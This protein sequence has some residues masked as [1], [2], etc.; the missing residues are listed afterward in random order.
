[1]SPIRQC[2]FI[3]L[4]APLSLFAQ[5]D[6][7]TRRKLYLE[8]T[9]LI[10]EPR[11]H[12]HG[13]SRRLNQK[14]STWMDWLN[15][16]G[17]LPPDFSKMKSSIF[18]PEPLTDHS[19]NQIKTPAQWEARRNWIKEQFQYW[20][21]GH[22][23]PAPDNITPKVISRKVED[24]AITELIEISFGPEN[25]AKM[26][27]ELMIPEGKGPFP[28]YMTQW[29]H[30]HWAQLA[31]RRG[32]IGCV[33]AGAD[34]KDDTQDYQ[35]IYP[36]YDFTAL[37]RRAWG[38]SRVVDY[39]N[40]R[41]EV[42]K[43]QIAITGH[44]RNGKQSLWAGAF[45]SRFTAV[46]SS[47]CGTG[48]VT[49][50]RFTDPQYYTQTLDDIA[51]NAAH[52]F[53]PRLR[54]FFGR[55][56]K[57]PIDQNLLLALIAPRNLLLHSSIIEQQLNPWATE[58]SYRSAKKVF[59]FFGMPDNIALFHRYGEH[60]VTTRDLEKCIDFLDQRFGR[61]SAKWHQE[62]YYNFSWQ[63]WA[64]RT[65]AVKEQFEPTPVTLSS[66]ADTSV[67]K[68]TEIIDNLQWLLGKAPA[69]VKPVDTSP[70]HPSRMDWISLTTGRPMVEGT[71]QIHYGPYT[72]IGDHLSATL[73]KPTGEK[74]NTLANKSGKIPIV[75][76]L[77]EYTYAHGYAY[78]YNAQPGRG[79]TALFKFLADK[80][81]AILA[82]DMLGFGTRIEEGKYFYD[83]FP[84]WSKMG[85]MT[86]DLR[87]C[88]DAIP[89]L[90][91]IDEER[92]MV[93]G[94]TIGGQVALLSAAMDNRIKAVATVAAFTPW[95]TTDT[96]K[97]TIRSVS[98]EHGLIPRLGLY[99]E[100]P[101]A[102]PV[103]FP[104]ILSTIAPRSLMVIAPTLDKYTDAEA[105]DKS[106]KVVKN[107]FIQYRQEDK[108]RYIT[109][110]EINRLTPEMTRQI[111]DYFDQV[112]K[113]N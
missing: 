67:G 104:E 12:R 71:E 30:R 27:F 5:S 9:L 72:G 66:A 57:L 7:L 33:Y 108:L 73:Y 82:F 16:T 6:E 40:T 8:E 99:Q 35:E 52:W 59:D 17:E 21:S 60:A 97:E 44:S 14:D 76:F 37:M 45:D 83:R 42:N 53:Q 26:T 20:I 84:E 1:M 112:S 38:A 55:E 51:S 93:L 58:Q 2:L 95:R 10:N 77:H 39:L 96:A 91:D 102:I 11:D 103:D 87:D 86:E 113:Q 111:G 63:E 88:I 43:E 98:A 41:N 24:G 28:V 74:K 36:E 54:F 46:I 70:T 85:K 101:A 106:M 29:N 31:V 79:N 13:I 64:S 18:L 109:P 90:E 80:G 56:D 4:I 48:G 100:N 69:K 78:G 50:Y 34:S 81:Y 22:I 15:R 62:E 47:S 65:K 107:T 105:L 19:G 32:Y 49:P 68:R 94:N 3:L 61:S 110:R 89:Y 75:I 92:I 25:K 23:P